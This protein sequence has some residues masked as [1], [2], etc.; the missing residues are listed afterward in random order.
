MTLKSKHRSIINKVYWFP[1]PQEHILGTET[2]IYPSWL[3]RDT[4]FQKHGI[5][6]R[7][8]H[9]KAQKL[10]GLWKLRTYK[11]WVAL[12]QLSTLFQIPLGEVRDQFHSRA[13][14]LPGPHGGMQALTLDDKE[15]RMER[16]STIVKCF[17]HC[18]G[19]PLEPCLNAYGLH[20]HFTCQIATLD[21]HSLEV[22]GLWSISWIFLHILVFWST[23][24]INILEV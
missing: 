4:C 21:Q 17:L 8:T 5:N 7:H 22:Q 19:K 9:S 20:Y 11:A 23:T 18:G 14:L 15:C 3:E 16:E 12:L 10:A 2:G 1:K 24:S 13:N 6:E